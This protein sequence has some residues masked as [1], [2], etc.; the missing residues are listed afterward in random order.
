MSRVCVSHNKSADTVTVQVNIS[1]RNHL[2]YLLHAACNINQYIIQCY[3]LRHSEC[4]PMQTINIRFN[5]QSIIC[6]LEYGGGYYKFSMEFEQQTDY[7]YSFRV[8]A[9]GPSSESIH[10]TFSR[11]KL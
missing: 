8:I 6:S 7:T 3:E 5:N 9:Q 4:D 1:W 2:P 10:G 11:G